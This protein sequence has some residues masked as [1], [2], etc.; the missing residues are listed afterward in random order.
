MHIQKE[1]EHLFMKNICESL[2]TNG[3]LILTRNALA[4]ISEICLEPSK[5]GHVNCKTAA[6][7]KSLSEVYFNNVFIFRMNDQVLHTGFHQCHI[8]SFLYVLSKRLKY[9]HISKYSQKCNT[10]I[11]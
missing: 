10:L 5:I 9:D 8:I 2:A 6:Q 3:S 1:D 11:L 4:K 7:L